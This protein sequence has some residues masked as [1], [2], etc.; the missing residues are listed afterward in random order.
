MGLGHQP[1][2][3]AH[4]EDATLDFPVFLLLVQLGI[5]WNI[6]PRIH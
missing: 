2:G 1:R 4:L 6:E 3:S 5:P